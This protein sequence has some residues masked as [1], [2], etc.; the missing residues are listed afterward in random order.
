MNWDS[1][2]LMSEKYKNKTGMFMY[3]N[4][5]IHLEISILC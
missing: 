3:K 5:L 2:S 1:N 4:R